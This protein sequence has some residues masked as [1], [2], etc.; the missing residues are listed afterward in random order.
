MSDL[1]NLAR[2]AAD[3]TV[4]KALADKVNERLKSV[5]ADMQAALDA[6]DGV[7]QVAAKLPDG[8][9]VAKVSLS[10][11]KPE[12]TVVDSEAFLAWVRENRPTEIERRVV[13]EVRP[14]FR[15]L[16]LGQITAAGVPDVVDPETGV[17]ESVPGVEV[18]A[19]RA[20]SHSVRFAKAGRERVAEAWRSGDLLSEVLGE[21]PEGGRDAD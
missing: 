9:E 4:L 10:D 19:T 2:L 13:T 14:A 1:E 11:P 6:A 3:E 15:T 21:L 16:L 20:R 18:R 5:R 17:V 7:R 12:A 8:T